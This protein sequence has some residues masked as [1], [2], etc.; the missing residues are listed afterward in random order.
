MEQNQ[1]SIPVKPPKRNLWKALVEAI[2]GTQA[3]YT[4]ISLKRCMILTLKKTTARTE[5]HK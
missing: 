5:S 3:D 1:P 4:R 2:K